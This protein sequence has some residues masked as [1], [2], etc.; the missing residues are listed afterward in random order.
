[1]L[2]QKFLFLFLFIFS[3]HSI[4]AINV[5]RVSARVATVADRVAVKAGKVAVKNGML[6]LYQ[7]VDP[8]QSSLLIGGGA[9]FFAVRACVQSAIFQT[10]RPFYRMVKKLSSATVSSALKVCK[11]PAQRFVEKQAQRYLSEL[12][13]VLVS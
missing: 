13:D 11:K 4:Q 3:G 8:I 10:R 7:G 1:M 2:K 12:Q 5:S 9:T 6:G